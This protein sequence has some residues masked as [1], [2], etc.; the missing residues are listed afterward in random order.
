MVNKENINL[1]SDEIT[2]ILGVPPRWIIRWGITIIF[3]VIAVVIIGSAFFSYPDIV[4]APVIITSENPPSA[5]LAR[6]SGKPDAIFFQDGSEVKNGDTLAVI[7]NPANYKDIFAL[8]R[9]LSNFDFTFPEQSFLKIKSDSLILGDIQP[10][11]TNFSKACNDFSIF[12]NQKLYEAKIKSLEEEL[13]QTGILYDRI[14]SQRNLM[15]RDLKLTEKQFSRDSQL[16]KTGVIA[17]VDFEKSQSVLISKRQ[18]FESLG[19]NLSNT[20]IAIERLKQNITDARFEQENQRKNL[21]ENLQNTFNQLKSSLASWEKSFLLIA[22]S[23]GRLTY[24]SFWSE[25]Q[26]VKAGDKLF[27][28]NPAKRG[29]IQARLTIPFERAGKVKVGQRVI[30]KLDGYPYLE[31]GVIEGIVNSIANGSSDKGYPCLVSLKNGALTSYRVNI[32]LDRELI[33]IAEITT[34][35]MTVIQRL[36][37]PL[38]HI[39]KSRFTPTT[40]N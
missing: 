24:M 36:L 6:V 7:E 39:F 35:E 30:I 37:N 14:W 18:S 8:E 33:G 34:E 12:A 11:F 5:V 23:S 13:K 4:T 31:F 40:K 29:E 22:P 15:L 38:K 1:R 2:E 25:L 10:A 16:F 32:D 19:L 26:E 27:T 28:I 3:I 21:V 17:E 9:W 20:S